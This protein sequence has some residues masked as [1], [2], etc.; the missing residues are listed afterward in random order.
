MYRTGGK[1]TTGFP[2]F[3][4]ST[5][6]LSAAATGLTRQ[7]TLML[8]FRVCATQMYYSLPLTSQDIAATQCCPTG[9]L[10]FDHKF[11]PVRLFCTSIPCEGPIAAR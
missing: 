6:A 9:N 4:V 2:P 3:T 1:E 10:L 8:P 7:N 11:K 5:A